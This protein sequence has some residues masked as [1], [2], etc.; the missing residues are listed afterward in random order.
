MSSAPMNAVK[1]RKEC[2]L[3]RR[4]ARAESRMVDDI[5]LREKQRPAPL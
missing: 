1:E 2:S 5:N 4:E 3:A